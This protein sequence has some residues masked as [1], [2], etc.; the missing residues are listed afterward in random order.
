MKFLHTADVHLD[1]AFCAATPTEAE[2]RRKYQRDT[3]VRIFELAESE[4]CD[5]ILIAGDLFDT[6]FV[7]PETAA[8]CLELFS[9]FKK[10]VIISPGN[11][12]PYVDG[13]FYKSSSLPKNVYVFSSPEL[14][15]FD[16][17]EIGVTVAGYAFIASAL[18]SAPLTAEL[19]RDVGDGNILLLCAHT[20]IDAPTSRYASILSSDIQRLGF[21]YAALGHVHNPPYI[22]E[23]VRYSGFPEGRAFDEDGEGGVYIV[24]LEKNAEPLIERR[25]TSRLCFKQAELSVDGASSAE[26]IREAIQN[27]IKKYSEQGVTHLRLELFGVVRD[28]V[29]EELNLCK[30]TL[31]TEFTSFEIENATLSLPDGSYLEKDVTLRG[32]LYRTLRPML[33][34]DD[35]AERS[36]ALRAL[37]IGL[38]AIEGK[39]FTD[40]GKA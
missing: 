34:S 7:T 32:E 13:G 3:L 12:D 35:S 2:E 16:I 14:Q 5:M 27:E 10:P 1:S 23:T 15:L 37:Q 4:S 26:Q 25:I 19:P 11:H 28:G 21:D 30:D 39:N 20:E 29:T 17:P 38:L 9:A 8:L 24:T 36:R 33:F 31:G 6:V 22:S 40:G 18:P